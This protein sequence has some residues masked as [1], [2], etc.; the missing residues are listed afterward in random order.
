MIPES[1]FLNPPHL[2]EDHVSLHFVG[3]LNH[4]P[5]DW[6]LGA[7]LSEIHRLHQLHGPTGPSP[8]GQVPSGG[9]DLLLVVALV[10]HIVAIAVTQAPGALGAHW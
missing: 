2:S 4:N 6:A 5:T 9:P 10:L 8:Q 7:M 3:Q 1:E